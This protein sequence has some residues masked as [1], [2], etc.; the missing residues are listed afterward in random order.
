MRNTIPYLTEQNTEKPGSQYTISTLNMTLHKF[1]NKI[2][3]RLFMVFS[4]S[5]RIL[6]Y[7]AFNALPGNAYILI[8]AWFLLIY[9]LATFET[10]SLDDLMCQS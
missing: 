6:S 8:S 9:I 7:L 5:V 4:S 10:F 3:F 2:P 1:S